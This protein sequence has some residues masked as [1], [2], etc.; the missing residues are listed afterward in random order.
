[1]NP[2][3]RA[4]SAKVD[5]EVLDYCANLSS[6]EHSDARRAIDL[7]PVAAE[8]ASSKNEKIAKKHVDLASD[9]LQKDRVESVL[10][11]A[12]YHLKL[13]CVSL[14]RIT[15]LSEIEWHST[16]L[17]YKQY[18]RIMSEGQKPLSYRRVSE[19]FTELENTGLVISQTSSKGRKGYGTQYK[20][21]IPPDVVG[22]TCFPDFWKSIVAKK[23][24][25]DAEEEQKKYR[26]RPKSNLFGLQ[27]LTRTLDLTNQ[28]NWKR[29]VGA[30]E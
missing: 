15:Y 21:V 3:S 23:I 30:N 16:S 9:S 8:M 14:A 26:I 6:Q 5:G 2:T 17:L 11:N 25:H 27:N 10:S 18:C 4:F 7:L 19:L 24:A 12:S 13:A 20:L 29:F 22:T 1:L 28:N